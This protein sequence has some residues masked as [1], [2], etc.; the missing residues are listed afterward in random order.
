MNAKRELFL[1]HGLERAEVRL[2]GPHASASKLPICWYMARTES[3]ELMS[4]RTSPDC[5]P[6]TTMSCRADKSS[7]TAVPMVPAPP[8]TMMRT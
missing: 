6:A 5:R 1:G 2:A 8:T 4:T 7:T 3:G